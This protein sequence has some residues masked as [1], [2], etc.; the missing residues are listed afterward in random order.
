MKITR[1]YIL[2]VEIIQILKWSRVIVMLLAVGKHWH[3]GL[4]NNITRV[5]HTFTAYPPT[6]PLFEARF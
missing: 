2:E 5:G 4:F 3:M 1:Y 6:L